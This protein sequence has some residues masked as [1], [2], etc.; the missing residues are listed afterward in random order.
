MAMRDSLKNK[1]VL[2]YTFHDGNGRIEIRWDSYDA[3]ERRHTY[4]YR[5][6]TSGGLMNEVHHEA[7]DLRSGSGDSINLPRAL[8][9]VLSFLDAF[10]EARVYGTA[11]GR[12]RRPD[13]FDLFPEHLAS[14]AE[15]M[16]EVFGMAREEI[17]PQS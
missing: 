13:N 5:I 10:A 17:D 14:W 9:T 11:S 8:G 3:T 7:D 12:S 6:F 2:S 16:H 4:H 15:S 1:S